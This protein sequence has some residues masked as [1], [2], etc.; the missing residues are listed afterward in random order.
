M[1]FTG[2]DKWSVTYPKKILYC[3]KFHREEYKNEKG[4]K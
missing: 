2:T 3:N 1:S 4:S